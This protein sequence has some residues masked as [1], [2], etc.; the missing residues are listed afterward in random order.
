MQEDLCKKGSTQSRHWENQ[1]VLKRKA[2]QPTADF[3]RYQLIKPD[4]NEWKSSGFVSFTIRTGNESIRMTENCVTFYITPKID[5]STTINTENLTLLPLNPFE[6]VTNVQGDQ[7]TTTGLQRSIYFNPLA[8]GPATLIS[9]CEIILDGQRVQINT[10]GFFSI[11]NTLNKLF[12]P[13]HVRRHSLGHNHILHN[14]NDVKT[15]FDFY[16]HGD[17]KGNF[18]AFIKNPDY[19]YALNEVNSVGDKIC[20]VS[21]DL[22]GMLF[23]SKPKNLG[24]NSILECDIGKNQ[25]A[26]LPPNCELKV[27]FRLNDPL[28]YRVIDTR[29]SASTFFSSAANTATSPPAGD[30]FHR[31]K[32]CDIDIDE[33]TLTI[34]KIRWEKEKIQRSMATG[35]INYEID[36]YIF[37]SRALEANQSS[38]YTEHDLPGN[39]GLAYCMFSRANQIYCDAQ[40]FRGSDGT[41]FALPPGMNKIE[42]KLNDTRIIFSQGLKISRD[43]CSYQRD[44]VQ[45]Y[46]YL[47]HRNLTDDSFD[48][49][50]PK[51]GKIGFKNAFPIDLTPYNITKPCKL[52]IYCEYINKSPS[53]Y[54]CTLFA[55]Q[56]V[57][58]FK[59]SRD[60]IWQSSA[61]VA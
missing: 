23:L 14:E 11:T 38:T 59:P 8:G 22:D 24:L 60:S 55:P 6:R 61:T 35:S 40:G 16:N 3:V 45:F 12:A 5:I 50:F 46:Q 34:E 7:T 36:Q 18:K 32:F 49:F 15:W 20:P 31:G 13:A 54:Y 19:E 25:H 58:I 42:F 43:D 2:V 39:I 10:G 26:I 44:A 53:D 57:N 48:S 17:D 4:N 29:M 30:R 33:I 9:E 37:R 52:G 21:G 1:G 56:S 28:Q 27:K 41:R 47:K 51:G